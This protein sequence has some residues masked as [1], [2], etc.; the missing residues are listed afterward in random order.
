MLGQDVY[1]ED[2]QDNPEG[3]DRADH[4]D[5]DTGTDI[6]TLTP[7]IICITHQKYFCS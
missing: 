6:T 3:G 4:D 2:E 1:N 7:G 5:D